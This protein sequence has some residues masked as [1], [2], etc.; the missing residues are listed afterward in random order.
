MARPTPEE[1]KKWYRDLTI[2]LNRLEG[3]GEEFSLFDASDNMSI[4]GLTGQ[5]YKSN[6]RVPGT[7][8]W[9]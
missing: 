6:T 9:Q 2:L 1:I 5:A 3:A 4:V 8:S 7:W